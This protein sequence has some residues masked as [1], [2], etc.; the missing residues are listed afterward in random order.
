MN[1]LERKYYWFWLVLTLVT[2]GS[3]GIAL[4]VLTNSLDEKAWY[5][6]YKYW[7]IGLVCLFYPF[8]VMAAILNIQLSCQVAAKL[9][10]PGKEIY[11]SP[12]IWLL[13]IIV[14][15]LGWIMLIVM[16]LYVEIWTIV[17]L[18]RGNGEKYIK[19]VV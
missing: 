18:Y 4:A 6:N 16:I 11:L 13:C 1:L 17:S 10:V 19:T 2:G 15:V 7:L 5:M 9:E 12:Y 3:S 8:L 14:P